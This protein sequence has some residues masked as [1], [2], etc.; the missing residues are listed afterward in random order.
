M[1]RITCSGGTDLRCSDPQSSRT[2]HSKWDAPSLPLLLSLPLTSL[3]L[4]RLSQAGAR[5]L[6]VLLS[7][8]GEDSL[9]E[10]VGF[11]IVW[12]DDPLCEKI[13]EA[14]KRIR[15]LKLGTR[16]TKLSDRGIV[17]I[18]EGCENLEVFVLEEVQGTSQ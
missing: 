1:C 3:H 7:N 13:V 8:L 4:S 2:C 9:L 6:S 15:S 14:G 18:V 11:D 5:A 10:D 12:L 16:G 17:K